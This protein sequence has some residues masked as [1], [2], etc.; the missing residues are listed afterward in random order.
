MS[1]CA[2]TTWSA[3][4]PKVPR[5]VRRP[6][7]SEWV[8]RSNRQA[9]TAKPHTCATHSVTGHPSS[10]LC[11]RT[12]LGLP[13][14]R[15]HGGVSEAGRPATAGA[16][17][18]SSPLPAPCWTHVAKLRPSSAW[19]SVWSTE[20]TAELHTIM[21]LPHAWPTVCSVAWHTFSRPML[22]TNCGP[23]RGPQWCCAGKDDKP[24]LAP[25][26]ASVA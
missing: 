6:I 4:P 9:H 7:T 2:L 1:T 3:R 23:G 26:L 25:V 22:P 20:R 17:A 11:C 14:S 13:K 8:L 12:V 21:R 15:P 24:W 16:D 19:H 10:A 5:P 18:T